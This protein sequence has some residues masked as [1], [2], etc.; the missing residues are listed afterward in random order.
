MKVLY[1]QEN[2]Y[3]YTAEAIGQLISK[4]L[5]MKEEI[6][7]GLPGGRSILPILNYL[8]KHPVDWEKIHVFVVD[9]RLVPINDPE[10]NFGLINSG[11]S[12]II[13]KENFHPFIIENQNERNSLKKYEDEIK[14]FDGFYDILVVSIGEDGHIGS[15]YPNHPSIKDD[16]DFYIIVED[17][18][19]PPSRRMSISSKMV[20]RSKA[21]VVIISG[22]QKKDALTKFL[23]SDSN[24][25]SCPAKLVLKIP[26]LFV[27]TDIDLKSINI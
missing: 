14:K 15:L 22:N 19:K 12:D 10:S 25:A 13:P 8:S 26:E 5:S 27:F 23:D 24:Y 21:C 3:E 2:L 11:L 17:S 16:S 1:E 4:F 9:E 18:P 20:T 6:V 7:L